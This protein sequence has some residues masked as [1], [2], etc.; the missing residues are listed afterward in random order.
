MK[1]VFLFLS[2]TSTFAFNNFIK[3]LKNVRFFDFSGPFLSK[4]GK[5]IYN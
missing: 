1:Y 2:Q 3:M 4:L 5:F